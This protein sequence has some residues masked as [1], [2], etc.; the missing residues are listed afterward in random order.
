[1]NIVW[2]IDAMDCYPHSQG[3]S[4][5]VYNAHWRCTGSDGV[6]YVGNWS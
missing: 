5:V 2:T 6:V 4:D 3:N 1:M